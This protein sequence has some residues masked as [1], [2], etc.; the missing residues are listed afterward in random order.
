MAKNRDKKSNDSEFMHPQSHDPNQTTLL[1]L[2]LD[3]PQKPLPQ[4]ESILTK[5]SFSRKHA[6][7]ADIF[8]FAPA[9][10]EAAVP[11]KEV[12]EAIV[13]RET[14]TEPAQASTQ[15]PSPPQKKRQENPPTPD[16]SFPSRFDG[17]KKSPGFLLWQVSNLWQR[18]QR[19]AL[20]EI[21]LTHIQFVLLASTMWLEQYKEPITQIRLS[22]QAQTDPMMTSQVVRV[23]VKSKWLSRRRHPQDSRAFALKLTP[24]G[25]E[26]A[27]RG[28]PLVEEVDGKFFSVIGDQQALLDIFLKLSG[29]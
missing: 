28:I 24:E 12:A 4:K 29:Q 26:L 25:R 27:S 18:Q 22:Q 15:E 7:Q 6:S 23:L 8:G 2:A 20:A 19:R 21:G 13:N 17:P 3:E 16:S 1:S 9:T 5:K 10:K 11:T 14:P